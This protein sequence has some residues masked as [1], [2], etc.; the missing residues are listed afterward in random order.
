[1][2]QETVAS[3]ILRN[4][5]T[6][7]VVTVSIREDDKGK[8][9]FVVP[10]KAGAADKVVKV[11]EVLAGSKTDDYPDVGDFGPD[12]LPLTALEWAKMLRTTIRHMGKSYIRAKLAKMRGS[13]GSAATSGREESTVPDKV[14]LRL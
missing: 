10:G 2:H 14:D 13:D 8:T 5:P 7:P 6:E 3:A 1:M 9:V 4:G 12:V 11:D